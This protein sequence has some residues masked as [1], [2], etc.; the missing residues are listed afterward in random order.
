MEAAWAARGDA[1]NDELA[2]AWRAARIGRGG[3]GFPPKFRPVGN[4]E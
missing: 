3:G 1:V 2:A 4:L